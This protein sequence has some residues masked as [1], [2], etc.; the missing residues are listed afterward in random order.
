MQE[1]K[2]PQQMNEPA[3]LQESLRREL[4]PNERIQ[5][6]GHPETKV[7]FAPA[8]IFLVPF[9]LLWA[10]GVISLG[11]SFLVNTPDDP[12]ALLMA[13]LFVA[14]GFYFLFGRFLYKN[15]RK[16]RTIYA[17]TD[18]RVITLAQRWRGVN[19]QAAFTNMIPTISKSVR[20]DGI[21]TLRFG[22]A[23]FLS[24]MYANTGM[25]WMNWFGGS[26]V[27][28]FYDVKDA[29]RIVEMVNRQRT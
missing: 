12:I 3:Q 8:D 20:R 22:N 1:P 15:Y 9:T 18:R 26:E 27:P 25:E 28:T 17:V 21:G 5:W 23:G 7:L 24:M 13:L 6:T 14:F 19:T 4:M 2:P 29:E 10:G 16:R 11:I